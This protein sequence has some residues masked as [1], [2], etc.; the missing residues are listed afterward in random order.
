MY[1]KNSYPLMFYKIIK[2]DW[3]QKKCVN[4]M[5]Y[6][7]NKIKNNNKINSSNKL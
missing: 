2:K 6:N 3:Y 1:K 5:D 4:I 7:T